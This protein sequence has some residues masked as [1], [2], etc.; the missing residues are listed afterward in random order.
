MACSGCGYSPCTCACG[1]GFTQLSGAALGRTLLASLVPCIDKIRDIHTQFGARP[2]QV[3]LV[4]TQW[5]GGAR[6]VGIEETTR[7]E[8]LLPTPLVSE[9]T[10][11]SFDMQAVG[12]NEGG[13]LRI[14]EIS[15]R[16]TEDYLSGRDEAGDDIAD[17]VSFYWEVTFMQKCGPGIRRRF[18]LS[19][20]PSLNSTKFEWTAPLVKVDE[21]RTRSGEVRG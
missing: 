8:A 19:A 7:E 3:M 17:D 18:R 16:Y 20:A 6:G 10:S 1:G 11:V 14:S 9:L 21:D 13:S 12:M 4:W 5:S 15:A 2:Y